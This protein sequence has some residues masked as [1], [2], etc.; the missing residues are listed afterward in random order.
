MLPDCLVK[1]A[2][3]D[4][5]TAYVQDDDAHLSVRRPRVR[6]GRGGRSHLLFV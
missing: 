4:V 2:R 1:R 3:V 5:G 6:Y